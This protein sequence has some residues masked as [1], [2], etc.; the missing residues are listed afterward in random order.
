VANN[1]G[2]GISLTDSDAFIES[3]SISSNGHLGVNI[4]SSSLLM[5][6]CQ[7]TSNAMGSLFIDDMHDAESILRCRDCSGDD[8]FMQ[9]FRTSQWPQ[10]SERLALSPSYRIKSSQ[11]SSMMDTEDET[12]DAAAAASNGEADEEEAYYPHIFPSQESKQAIIMQS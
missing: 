9:I 5:S 11:S 2:N 10:G 4:T 6:S 7:V 12:M 8:D 1:H 3:T